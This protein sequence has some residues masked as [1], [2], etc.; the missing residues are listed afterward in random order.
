MPAAWSIKQAAPFF[1]R[2]AFI[3]VFSLA[4]AWAVNALRP[5]PLAWDWRPPAPTAPGLTDFTALDAALAKPQ[6]V[7]VDARDAFFY[8]MGHLPSAVS[9]PL[10]ATGTDE[11]ETWRSS[12]LPEAEIIIYC[13]D[14]LCP[15]ADQLAREMMSLGLAPTVFTPGFDAWEEKGR[16]VE[17]SP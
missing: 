1:G 15:M 14:S 6:T 3:I 17:V 9:L 2:A 16:P 10:E 13:S 8:Q 12:L 4:S 7:L 5:E 11:L